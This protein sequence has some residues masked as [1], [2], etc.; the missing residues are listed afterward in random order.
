MKGMVVVTSADDGDL[1]KTLERYSTTTEV[2]IR[3]YVLRARGI[4]PTA[5]NGYGS[6]I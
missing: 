5:E 3:V 1:K 4:V 6:N 2:A